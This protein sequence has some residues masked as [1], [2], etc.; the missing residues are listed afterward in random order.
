MREPT[1][2]D[3]F[4]AAKL[5]FPTMTR[6]ARDAQHKARLAEKFVFDTEASARVGIVL[7]DVPE[8]LVEQIQFARPPFDL[9]WIEY[10]VETI[11]NMLNPD[12]VWTSDDTRDMRLGLLIEHH[13]MV[14]VAEDAQGRFGFM[15]MVYHLNTEWKLDEQLVFA[16]QLGV[17]RIGIDLW[18]WG[19]AAPKLIANGKREYLRVLRDTNRAELLLP[20]PPDKAVALHNGTV[21][22][23]KN[24]VGMLLM[25]NQ[26]SLTQYALVPRTRGWI[27]HRPKPYMAHRE[28]R[29]ASDPVPR[30]RQL[31]HGGGE[32]SLRRRHRVRG[33]YCTNAQAR[34][35]GCI[36]QWQA[37]GAEW[38][39]VA[40]AVGDDP[41]RWVC[42]VCGGR[43]WWRADHARGDAGLG[44]VEH[45]YRVD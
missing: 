14:V 39:P 15:P 27:G 36:H 23:F 35:G 29:V 7:R 9:C 43:R 26:P 21:G 11:F 37:A 30:V 28:V 2:A 17:S 16:E 12:R 45:T 4:V 6:F 40:V 20:V 41:E 42:D 32:G 24:H 44:W 3:R 25:L 10:D 22:D 1:M 33:H 18:L 8:L 34:S 31:S 19:A 5:S 13:R 38:K